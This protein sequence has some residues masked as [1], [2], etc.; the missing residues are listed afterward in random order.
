MIRIEEIEKA[1]MLC[2]VDHTMAVVVDLLDAFPSTKLSEEQQKSKAK[3]YMT[4]LEGMPTWAVAEAR[5]RWLQARA[6]AQNYDFAPSPPRLREI[7][8]Y[9]LTEVR[10]QRIVLCRLL[11]AKPDPPFE[12]SNPRVIEGF[13]DLLR[14]LKKANVA[15]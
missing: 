12:R 14:T 2:D 4:A 3:G 7:S 9:V 11:N 1:E 10:G 15:A 5:V 6:G 8:D 13:N